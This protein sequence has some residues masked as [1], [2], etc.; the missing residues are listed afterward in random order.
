MESSTI[1]AFPLA[2]VWTTPTIT[3]LKELSDARL[4]LIQTDVVLV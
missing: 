1:E 3:S 4:D 2:A